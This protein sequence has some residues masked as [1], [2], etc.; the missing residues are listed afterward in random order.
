MDEERHLNQLK[1][2][3]K[4]HTTN[5]TLATDE[6]IMNPSRKPQTR[7]SKCLVYILL[8]LVLQSIALLIFGLV[9]LRI[10]TPSLRLSALVVKDLHYEPTSLNMTVVAEVRLHNMNFGRFE[11]RGGNTTFL[12]ENAT[13]GVTGIYDGRVGSRDKRE[14][15][16]SVKVMAS[17][18]QLSDNSMDFF[19]RDVDSGLIQ[20]RS[21]AKLKGQV[22]LV[23]IINR[24]TTTVMNCTMALNLTSQAIQG[25][26]CQ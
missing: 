26:L 19:S 4:H 17:D 5:K 9:V 7:S 23:K 8:A 16:V 11:F 22:R 13:V 18:H 1:P 24:E 2:A 10:R 21:F 20:L 14:M 6:L 3:R 25:L 12:Y 15:N